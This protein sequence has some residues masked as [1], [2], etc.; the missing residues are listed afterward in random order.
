LPAIRPQG[1]RHNLKDGLLHKSKLAQHAY[2]EGHSVGWMM[3]GFWK[4]KVT[5]GIQ[6]ICPYGMLNQSNQPKSLD[7][8]PIWIPLFSN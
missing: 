1:H 4:L 7:V 8:S 6:E 2:E 3:L 5:E